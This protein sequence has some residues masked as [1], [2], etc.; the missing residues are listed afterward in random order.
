MT[1]VAVLGAG[2]VGTT[3]ALYLQKHGFAVT[4]IERTQPGHETSYG[5]AGIIDGGNVLPFP[6]P[7]LTEAASILFG[8]NPAARLHWPSLPDTLPW[9]FSFWRNSSDHR[10]HQHGQ[11]LRPLLAAALTEHEALLKDASSEN[12][13]HPQGRVRLYRT[14]R[15][16]AG[17]QF[18]QETARSFGIPFDILTAAELCALEPALK[19]AFHKA[20][21]WTGSWRVNNPAKLVETYARSF[22]AQGGHILQADICEITPIQEGWSLQTRETTSHTFEKIVI[23]AG[24]WSQK[25]LA[26]LG[27][28]YPLAFKRGYHVHYTIQHETPLQHALVD[29]DRGYVM[30]QMD[31]GLR[32]TSG[33]EFARINSPPNPVQL[34]QILPS[35]R[36]LIELGAP[37]SAPIWMGSRPCFPDSLPLIGAAPRHSGLWF[38]FGHGHLGLTLGPASARLLAESMAGKPTFCSPSPYSAHRFD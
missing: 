36:E 5:N 34:Q 27:Y 10:R 12:I 7:P 17:S 38:N 23:C 28:C 1:T 18:E 26:P 3:T 6:C 33:A 11:M 37:T 13:L 22:V 24:P 31:Q 20:I 14:E 25:L 30:S 8:T 15:S 4:L 2:I 21:R 9:I 32:L 16:F 19:P 35:V 29:G